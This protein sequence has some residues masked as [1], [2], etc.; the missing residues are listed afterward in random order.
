MKVFWLLWTFLISGAIPVLAA[1]P[2]PAPIEIKL[3]HGDAAETQT[4]D[5]LLRLLRTYDASRW[6]FTR[7][8]VIDS[9][10]GTIPH[11]HPV[12]TLS[13]RHLKD[14]DLLLSTFLHENLHHFLSQNHE[15]AE[16]A[17]KELRAAFP[18]VPVGYP[19]G[20]DSDD[21]GYTHLIVNY[22]EYWADKELLGEQRAFQVLQFWMA[23]HYR[24]LYRQLLESGYQIGPIVRKNGLI[25]REI[26][27]PPAPG[28]R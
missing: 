2:Q 25:P 7:S 1:Q 15:K 20:A 6:I 8:V 12:L 14:D 26:E 16:A 24:W 19:D 17:K 4:R 10:P 21:A 28:L 27:K 9:T 3:Q 11:S 5:Q 23:D 13:V 22:L 18:K